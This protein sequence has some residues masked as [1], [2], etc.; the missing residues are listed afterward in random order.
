MQFIAPSRMWLAALLACAS[1][2][3]QEPLADGVSAFLGGG[4]A[5]AWFEKAGN[6]WITDGTT[7]E[8]QDTGAATGAASR[9]NGQLVLYRPHRIEVIGPGPSI[10]S[11]VPPIQYQGF[12]ADA[13]HPAIWRR[14]LSEPGAEILE[15]WEWSGGRWSSH[16]AGVGP[17]PQE[18]C[19]IDDVIVTGERYFV[20]WFNEYH[21]VEYVDDLLGRPGVL[22]YGV[23]LTFDGASGASRRWSGG[24]LFLGG[25]AHWNYV[26][27]GFQV[28][29]DR[30]WGR[31]WI[32]PS[33]GAGGR[34]TGLSE[35]R[36]RVFRS[37]TGTPAR[38][39]SAS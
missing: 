16:F 29:T 11:L 25:M 20:V 18:S 33:T 28:A 1:S 8:T 37:A 2:V 24:V 7:A 6:V 30:G 14:V 31:S 12:D 36:S 13:P 3:A 9:A 15:V 38:S 32:F 26:G 22:D 23:R 39:S 17:P 35:S 27:D 4:P 10:T 34:R 19:Y 21:Y 5:V